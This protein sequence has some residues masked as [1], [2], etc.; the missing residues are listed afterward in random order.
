MKRHLNH[1]KLY[2]LLGFVD[3]LQPMMEQLT[4][5]Y[6]E[7]QSRIAVDLSFIEPQQTN[8][9]FSELDIINSELQLTTQELEAYNNFFEFTI[10]EP[11]QVNNNSFELI[12]ANNN[13]ESTIILSELQL[14]QDNNNFSKS[15]II[16]SELQTQESSDDLEFA[17]RLHSARQYVLN[18][19]R[20]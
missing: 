20:N 12:Q 6:K 2:F 9:N 13:S 11:E 17:R 8:N 7:N 16:T 18:I 10:Q 15:I 3:Y 14:E 4:K 1:G 19:I 5:N